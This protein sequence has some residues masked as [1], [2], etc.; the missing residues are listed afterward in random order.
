MEEITQ[1]G[2][3]KA[4]FKE[5]G[6]KKL[7]G[8]KRKTQMIPL[9]VL[10]IGTIY[11]LLSL[12][13]LS[14]GPVNDFS[15]ASWLG[16]SVFVNTLFSVL[17]LVLFLN[18]FPKYPKVNKK[19][20]KKSYVNYIMM[21][22]VFVFIAVMIAMDILY[23]NRMLS[24]IPK[25]ETKFFATVA[26]ANRFKAYWDPSFDVSKINPENAAKTAYLYK[27][28]GILIGHIVVISIAAILLATLPLYKKLIMKIDTS[29]KIEGTQL[30]EKIDTE[31]E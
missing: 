7:V 6:R 18:V 12:S 23:Y 30:K 19:T 10:V 26:Q 11:Y 25:N 5:W 4:K 16:F 31:D 13:I 20:G 21:A 9:L 1:K 24:C 17:V 8:L 28:F 14:P 27:S 3:F 29:K 22:L 2:G 15:G